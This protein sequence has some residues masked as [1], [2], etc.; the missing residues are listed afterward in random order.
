M[1]VRTLAAAALALGLAA[2]ANASTI[3]IVPGTSNPW[4][5]GMPAGTTADAGDVAPAQSPVEIAVTAGDVLWIFATG[6][7]DHC[8]GFACGAAGAEGDLPEGAWSHS[9]GAEHGISDVIAPIDALLGVFLGPGQPDL[10]P[11]PGTLDFSNAALRDFL[12]LNP[13]LKQTFFIGDGLRNDGVTA[14]N[15][16]VPFGATRLFLGPM[17]GFEWNNNS[18][19]LTVTAAPV[20]E[21]TTLTLFGLG[22]AGALRRRLA[23]RK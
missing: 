20:P 2:S 1:F 12:T 17:D 10:T 15:F 6:A 16:V 23:S 5:A 7:T 21:P 8:P 11:A 3:V 14:Q 22:L 4:L 18:G 13:L 19:A 9:I